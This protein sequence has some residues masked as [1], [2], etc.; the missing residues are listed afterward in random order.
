[1]MNF[2]FNM[3][4]LY[5]GVTEQTNKVIHHPEELTNSPVFPWGQFVTPITM[6]FTILL[7]DCDYGR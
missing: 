5:P 6:Y 1:M 7:L 2:N 3:Y 4:N